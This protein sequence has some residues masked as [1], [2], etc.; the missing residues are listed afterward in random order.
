MAP[1]GYSKSEDGK[2]LV[3]N[4]NAETVKMMFQ[5]ALEGYS[6]C[7]I[8]TMMSK[9]G[10]LIPKAEIYERNNDRDNPHYPKYPTLW[11]SATVRSILLNPTYTGGTYAFRYGIKSYKNKQAIRRPEEDWIVTPNTHEALISE[12]DFATVSKRISV[13]THDYVENPDNI[14]RG[15]PVCHDCGCRL[16]FSKFGKSHRMQ[17][18]VGY[19]KCAN[20]TRTGH[21]GC[22]SHYIRFEQLYE[23]VLTDIQQHTL[24]IAEDKEKYVDTLLKAS[25]ESGRNNIKALTDELEKS[26]KRVTELDKLLQKLYEDNALGKLSDSRYKAMSASME[27]EYDSLVFRCSEIRGRLSATGKARKNTEDFAELIGK[28]IG[29]TELNYEVLHVLIDKIVVYEK[30]ERDGKTYQ[31]IDIYYRFIGNV[32]NETSLVRNY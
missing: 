25:S 31:K 9:K 14:F 4:K 32:N 7:Q 12:E 3:P 16:G 23:L 13:K 27:Q 15:L 29:I 5:L 24:L 10:I 1:Y 2:K 18:S 17:K 26:Q 6:S 28:Y 21:R 22:S 19:Y 30:E 20:N 11:L 8:A